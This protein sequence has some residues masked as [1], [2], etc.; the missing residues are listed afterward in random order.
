MNT[1]IILHIGIH[2]TGTS[3]IQQFL[4]TNSALLE[5]QGIFYPLLRKEWNNHNPLAW[6]LM[7][8]KYAPPN[9]QYYKKYG[10]EEQWETLL[11]RISEN[12]CHT[13]LLSGEDF[14]LVRDPARL[15]DLLNGFDPR[16]ILYLRRQDQLLQSI[17]NQDV[18]GAAW[19][20]TQRFD[21]FL[22]NHRLDDLI[23]YDRFLNRWVSVFGKK[24]LSVGVYEKARLRNGLIPD[25]VERAGIRVDERFVIPSVFENPSLSPFELELKR[26]LNSAK[27]S[28]SENEMLLEA[29]RTSRSARQTRS[30]SM[31]HHLM[32]PSKRAAFMKTHHEGNRRVAKRFFKEDSLL[33]SSVESDGD[34]RVREPDQSFQL[35]SDVAPL[36]LDLLRRA[37][38]QQ[39]QVAES[40]GK[41]PSD[42]LSKDSEIIEPP[43]SR[44]AL[45]EV[46]AG[47]FRLPESAQ[48][49][50]NLYSMSNWAPIYLPLLE[51]ISPKRIVEIG[52]ELGGN[53]AVLE[54]FCIQYRVELH[55]VDTDLK[56][57]TEGFEHDMLF[58]HQKKSI[59]FFADFRGAQVYFIDADHNYQSVFAELEL[60][61]RAHK[62]EDPLLVILHDTGWPCGFRDCFYDPS[63]A[64][65]PKDTI[66]VVKGPVPWRS[67]L[68]EGGFGAALFGW[69]NREGGAKNGVRHAIED[70]V[71]QR[72]GWSRMYFTPFYGICFLWLESSLSEDLQHD[73]RDWL[74]SLER[75]EPI[76]ATLEWNRLLLYLKIQQGGR[77]WQKQQDWIRHLE[78]ELEIQ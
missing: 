59:D 36:V 58:Y 24:R 14:A 52:V 61:G 12:A 47:L 3:A 74:V 69:K 68:V 4:S 35:E 63:T 40:R 17:Y 71:G 10:A 73:I 25:F 39:A 18:K 28:A 21:E 60:I 65:S 62:K 26:I 72:S 7:D 66:S 44:A 41:K 43:F 78:E 38:V 56:A 8:P 64:E 48:D 49:G 53:T 50:E 30:S 9:A 31:V 75:A 2:K 67:D 19:M 37:S 45:T 54:K 32:S 55:L 13:V 77:L 57:K 70:F 1:K 29:M 11:D 20:R 76:F 22:N 16:I 46:S 33:F 6:C 15:T 27:L 42:R 51:K 5:A 34:F 23:R